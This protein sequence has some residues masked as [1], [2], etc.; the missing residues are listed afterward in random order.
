M[1]VCSLL[2]E[3]DIGLFQDVDFILGF[4]LL[5]R[6]Q[7]AVSGQRRVPRTKNLH[8]AGDEEGRVR[9]G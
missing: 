3:D 4:C 2:G 8:Q 6:G 5:S 1:P 7:P 9:N